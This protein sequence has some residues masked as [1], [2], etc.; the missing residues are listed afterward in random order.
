MLGVNHKHYFS[1]YVLSLKIQNEC[2]YL[3]SISSIRFLMEV[4]NCGKNLNNSKLKSIHV[5]TVHFC[6]KSNF[7]KSLLLTCLLWNLGGFSKLFIDFFWT[8]LMNNPSYLV[9]KY[10][11]ISLTAKKR[12]TWNAHW[13][14]SAYAGQT[15]SRGMG[16]SINNATRFFLTFWPL[17]FSITYI[18][19]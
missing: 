7:N 19:Y 13:I 15:L 16:S 9:S 1:K 14:I 3:K 10:E 17:P 12:R 18:F 2:K 11:E 4:L 8:L 6:H 5:F